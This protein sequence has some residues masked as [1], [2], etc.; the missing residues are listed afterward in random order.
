MFYYARVVFFLS[1]LLYYLP[2][3]LRFFSLSL[4]YIRSLIINQASLIHIVLFMHMIRFRMI[5]W[6][7]IDFFVFDMMWIDVTSHRMIA[8]YLISVLLFD[9]PIEMMHLHLLDERNHVTLEDMC[10]V[11]IYTYNHF[12]LT[13]LIVIER[14]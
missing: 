14:E 8:Y 11:N 5:F 9:W 3:I 7:S 13:I 4:L 12:V 1:P 2:S 6:S 10:F